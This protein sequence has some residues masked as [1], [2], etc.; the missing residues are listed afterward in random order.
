MYVPSVGTTCST[1]HVCTTHVCM[2]NHIYVYVCEASCMYVCIYM[3]T[4]HF[5]KQVHIMHNQ[6]NLFVSML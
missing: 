5:P 1:W 4:L 2:I 6:Q 3:H